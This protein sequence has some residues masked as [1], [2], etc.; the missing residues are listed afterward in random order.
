[1]NEIIKFVKDILMINKEDTSYIG[2]TRLNQKKAVVVTQAK[3][4]KK[5]KNDVKL[6]DLM[7]RVS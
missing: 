3:A 2:L 7:K 4:E 5:D 1:M 6:S